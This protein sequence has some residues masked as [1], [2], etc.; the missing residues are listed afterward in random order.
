MVLGGAK[1]GVDLVSNKTKSPPLT[2]RE[3]TCIIYGYTR[4]MAEEAKEQGLFKDLSVND[5][6]RLFLTKN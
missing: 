1:K 2:D 3:K 6:I 5:V 4:R